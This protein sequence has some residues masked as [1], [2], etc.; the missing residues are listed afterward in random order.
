MSL[1]DPSNCVNYTRERSDHRARVVSRAR[2]SHKF[3]GAELPDNLCEVAVGMRT[4]IAS[5][6][7]FGVGIFNRIGDG[8]WVIP[9]QGTLS[10]PTRQQRVRHK[11]TCTGDWKVQ[12]LKCDPCES[13]RHFKLKQGCQKGEGRV[14]FHSR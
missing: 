6:Y 1:S 14:H 5:R 3:V 12:T 10:R 9:I 8:T 11:I 2:D 4:L 7:A 13:R